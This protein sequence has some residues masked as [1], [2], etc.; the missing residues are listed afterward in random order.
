MK[1][2]FSKL[3]I[4]A[5]ITISAIMPLRAEVLGVAHD[6]NT[7]PDDNFR[8]YLTTKFPTAINIVEHTK[9]I[10]TIHYINLAGVGNDTPWDGINIVIT[11]Y[12]DGTQKITKAVY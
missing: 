9:D 1:T 4:A 8:S 7:F 12:D 3:A 11:T 5:L 10:A 2:P 6:S